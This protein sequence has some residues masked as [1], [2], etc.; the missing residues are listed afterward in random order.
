MA[1]L[2]G[3]PLVA[4][5]HWQRVASAT[6]VVSATHG[7]Y[8][9]IR[10]LFDYDNAYGTRTQSRRDGTRT[11]CRTRMYKRIVISPPGGTGNG[12]NGLPVADGQEV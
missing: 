12:L 3:Q 7:R 2:S 6:Q 8:E 10:L 4:T 9:N 11:R 5:Q 1:I